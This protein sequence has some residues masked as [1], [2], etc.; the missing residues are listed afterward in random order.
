MQTHSLIERGRYA[1]GG[2]ETH[3]SDYWKAIPSW[4]EVKGYAAHG[5]RQVNR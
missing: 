2:G 3:P 4:E 1:F 5:T